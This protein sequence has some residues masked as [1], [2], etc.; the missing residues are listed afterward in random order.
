VDILL[1]E[2]TE[3]DIG[4]TVA[5]CRDAVVHARVDVARDGDGALSFLETL[6][7]TSQ[8]RDPI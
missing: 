2:D 4:L 5:A 3:A 1:V 8:R 7:I 6:N